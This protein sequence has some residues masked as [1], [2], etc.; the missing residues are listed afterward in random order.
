LP[1]KV[2]GPR[3]PGT[4]CAP[5]LRRHAATAIRSGQLFVTC[6]AEGCGRSL[7]TLELREVRPFLLIVQ[8]MLPVRKFRP[9]LVFF[10][11]LLLS[12]LALFLIFSCFVPAAAAAAA[13]P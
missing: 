10:V 7:Q 12:Q 2:S 4:V 13:P 6:P 11:A 1:A 8:K 9:C 5:C 3:H